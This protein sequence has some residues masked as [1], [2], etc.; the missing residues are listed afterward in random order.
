MYFYCSIVNL[1]IQISCLVRVLIDVNG[2]VLYL[3]RALLLRLSLS[4]ALHFRSAGRAHVCWC[5]CWCLG[6]WHRA[7]AAIQSAANM[8]AAICL[9]GWCRQTL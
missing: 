3:C 8:S 4:N 6:E 1:I 9:R 2:S 7:A 5:G